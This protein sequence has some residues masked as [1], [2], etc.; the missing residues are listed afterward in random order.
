MKVLGLDLSLTGTGVAAIED[1]KL[2][3][4]SLIRSK[5][6]GP[7]PKDETK[8]ILGIVEEI[9]K[10][11]DEFEPELVVIEGLAFMARNSTALVQLAGLNYLIRSLLYSRD[12][13]FLIVAPS[14]LKKFITGKGNSQKDVMMLETYKQYGISLLDDNLVDAH[15]LAQVGSAVLDQKGKINKSQMEVVHLISSQVN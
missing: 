14:T 3:S 15:G 13:K 7:R 8:R 4:S 5:P 2:L 12:I 10:K 1:G 11:I 9:T 6:S